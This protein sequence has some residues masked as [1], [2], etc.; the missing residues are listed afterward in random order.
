MYESMFKIE[1][2]NIDNE[3]WYNEFRIK[4]TIWKDNNNNKIKLI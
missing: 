2:K 3:H 1:E 4:N